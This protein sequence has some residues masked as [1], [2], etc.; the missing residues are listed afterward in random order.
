MKYLVGSCSSLVGSEFKYRYTNCLCIEA[1]TDNE[2]V[3][4]YKENTASYNMR[5][6]CCIGIIDDSNQLIIDNFSKR[7]SSANNLPKAKDGEFYHLVSKLLDEPKK[8]GAF[9]LYAPRYVLACSKDEAMEKY[10]PTID[11]RFKH[12]H[13]GYLDQED[14]FI[15]AN[16]FDY[17]ES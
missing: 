2:A 6:A 13:L 14:N 15:V 8:I 1:D 4:I 3:K 17:I 9:S 10:A 16:I 12:Y 11:P 5:F 7:Y